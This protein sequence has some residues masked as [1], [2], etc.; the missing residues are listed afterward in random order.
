[1]QSFHH[2]QFQKLKSDI[3]HQILIW[4]IGPPYDFFY[5][6]WQINICR[7]LCWSSTFHFSKKE[8]EE[9]ANTGYLSSFAFIVTFSP[10]PPL[11]FF[12]NMLSLQNWQL[13]TSVCVSAVC[14]NFLWS[15][16]KWAIAPMMYKLRLVYTIFCRAKACTFSS[17][18]LLFPLVQES[19]KDCLTAI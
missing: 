8:E 2:C 12:W 4:A 16:N 18:T 1:M 5:S 7:E 14:T 19:C 17:R 6:Y 9:E 3:R 11:F 15:F 10:L 13:K